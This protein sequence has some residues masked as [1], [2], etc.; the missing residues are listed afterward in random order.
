M[1]KI[2]LLYSFLAALLIV[3][4][5]IDRKEQPLVIEGID[6]NTSLVRSSD[7]LAGAN[8][9][10]G[11]LRL[12][13]G[14]DNNQDGVLQDS[15]VTSTSYVC[16]GIDGKSSLVRVEVIAGT[17]ECPNGGVQVS[18]GFDLN[19]NG[20][21]EDSEV[22]YSTFVCNGTDGQDGENG[23]NSLV[24]TETIEE[25]DLCEEG[26]FLFKS[27]LDTNQNGLLDD[28]EVTQEEVVCN[29]EDGLTV[30]YNTTI[31]QESESCPTGGILIETGL[32]VNENGELDADEVSSTNFICNGLNGIDG[33]NGYNSLVT[34]T[35]IEGG[36]IIKSGLDFN[37]NNILEESE[38]MSTSTVYDG[39]DGEDGYN[40]LVKLD[41]IPPSTTYPTGGVKISSGLDLN[42]NNV[43]N[44][45]EIT[46]IAFVAN[47]QNGLNSLINILQ[48]T[49][50]EN[51][52]T[53]Q[54]GIDLNNNGIL[55]QSEVTQETVIE[56][57]EDGEDGL[58]GKCSFI[59]V[60]DEPAGENCEFGG[61]KIITGKDDNR[62][63]IFD[64]P[65]EVDQTEYVCEWRPCIEIIEEEFTFD[66]EIFDAGDIVSQ[67]GIAG[68]YGYRSSFNG[69]QFM[70]FDSENPTGGDWDLEV[71]QGNIAIISEDN[72]SSDPDDNGAGGV[73]TFTFN[74]DVTFQ[75]IDVIDIEGQHNKIKFY[76]ANDNEI[77]RQNLTI[78]GN[79]DVATMNFNIQYV[80]KIVV[81]ICESGAIDN[82]KFKCV[83]TINNCD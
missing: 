11:G 68:V 83:T 58:D 53:V 2:N 17:E 18:T 14:V 56:D 77:T 75:A 48:N 33:T 6:G 36:V 31:I 39:E 71:N 81:S 54:V 16:N 50:N 22:A 24:N 21:L 40:S 41:Q 34:T 73:F 49:P 10:N 74:K 51:S 43:L 44:N 64:I 82:L 4:C 57:G 29:G 70:I 1:R 69:N 12:D 55:E 30:L 76:D 28:D 47:G 9:E 19:G 23:Y 25:G 72:D 80:R 15:E 79:Q 67:Y 38:V 26:G 46:N 66:F 65:E 37:R 13:F 35:E 5:S 3:S 45:S 78:S 7:E 20:E 52:N 60:L 59:V 42:R 8:C 61:V 27:G 63:L 32:D 62:N